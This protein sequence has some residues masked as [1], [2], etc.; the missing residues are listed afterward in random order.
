M[1]DAFAKVEQARDEWLKGG[2]MDALAKTASAWSHAGVD[3]FRGFAAAKDGGEPARRARSAVQ[4]DR[5][6]ELENRARLVSPGDRQPLYGAYPAMER[7]MIR[8]GRRKLIVPL[9][10]DPRQLSGRPQAREQNLRGGTRRLSSARAND[11]ADIL[12][13]A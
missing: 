1:S 10:R 12:K 7:Y 2:A 13:K 8:I 3:P 9:Y 6:D 5:V 4:A 11:I